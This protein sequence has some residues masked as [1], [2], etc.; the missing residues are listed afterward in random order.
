MQTEL[1]YPIGTE[2]LFHHRGETELYYIHKHQKLATHTKDGFFMRY[3]LRRLSDDHQVSMVSEKGFRPLYE[4]RE[5][6][7][8]KERRE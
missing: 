2:V 1:K 7:I 6:K 8:K 5:N 3:I 4:L